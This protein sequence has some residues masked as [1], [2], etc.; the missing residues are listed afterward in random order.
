MGT[1]TTNYGFYKPDPTEFVNVVS[2]LNDNL[3]HIDGTIAALDDLPRGKLWRTGGFSNLPAVAADI[4]FEASRV[5]FGMSASAGSQGLVVPTSGLYRV[6]LYGYSSG[7]GAPPYDTQYSAYRI[8]AATANKTL[9]YLYVPKLTA[10]D[11]A[12]S[13]TTE[14]PLAAGDEIRVQGSSTGGAVST[15]GIDEA[16]GVRLEVEF[17]S[18]LLGATPI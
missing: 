1:T 16:S 13:G 11:S 8:R 10:A 12:A 18:P 9:V 3:D 4:D 14:V 5:L 7:G 17:K 15:W 2:N 6:Y